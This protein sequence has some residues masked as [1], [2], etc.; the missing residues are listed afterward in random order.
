VGHDEGIVGVCQ[1]ARA[2][3]DQRTKLAEE[4][5]PLKRASQRGLFCWRCFVWQIRGSEDRNQ[6]K[7]PVVTSSRI[8]RARNDKFCS[9]GRALIKARESFTQ[10]AR[11][12][13]IPLKLEAR[14]FL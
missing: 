7:A 11:F 4:M 12:P 13:W 8:K 10:K 5:K 2:N 3:E 9:E 14:L 1:A 6:I